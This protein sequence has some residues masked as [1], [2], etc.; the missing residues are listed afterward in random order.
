MYNIQ[1]VGSVRVLNCDRT[2]SCTQHRTSNNTQQQSNKTEIKDD[3]F[4]IRIKGITNRNE[5]FKRQAQKHN[6]KKMSLSENG[7]R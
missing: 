6:I 4:Q 2:L 1:T 7:I 5:E 3:F